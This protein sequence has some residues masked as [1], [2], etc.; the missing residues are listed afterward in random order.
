M[1]EN[2]N[3]I[4][5]H[6]SVFNAIWHHIRKFFRIFWVLIGWARRFF[7]LAIL[8][9]SISFSGLMVFSGA[10]QTA[11]TAAASAVGLRTVAA[12]YLDDVARYSTALSVERKASQRL[13]SDLARTSEKLTK[14]RATASTTVTRVTRRWQ[15]AA[16]REVAVMPAEAIPA[17]G[18]A[19]IVAATAWELSDICETMKD[20]SRLEEALSTGKGDS[21]K[22]EPTVCGTEVPKRQELLQ[23]AKSA[24][25]KVWNDAKHAGMDLADINPSEIEWGVAVFK[26]PAVTGE[27]ARDSFQDVKDLLEDQEDNFKLWWNSQ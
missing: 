12:R 10:V 14:V 23:M 17:L 27:I 9:A 20:M 8:I 21:K 5:S 25:L 16:A 11:V 24:P 2:E 19:V 1:I 15:R 3:T 7:V 22:E 18:A 13:K 4:T 6:T 26:I